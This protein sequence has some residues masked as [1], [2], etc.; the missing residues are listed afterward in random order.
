MKKR[1]IH[2]EENVDINRNNISVDKDI[3]LLISEL[4][5]L[6]LETCACCEG[7]KDEIYEDTG[8]DLAYV[9]ICLKNARFDYHIDDDILT[10]RWNRSKVS[11]PIEE[12]SIRLDE[13]YIYI[14]DIVTLINIW[15][16]ILNN[17]ES[18]MHFKKS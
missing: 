5:R 6:G 8:D 16:D 4:N 11:I 17:H 18:V 9:S 1:T 7:E 13:N 3:I 2:E 10:I 14:D 15:R 12:S